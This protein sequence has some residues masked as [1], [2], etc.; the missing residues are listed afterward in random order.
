[1]DHGAAPDLCVPAP[2]DTFRNISLHDQVHKM[3]DAVLTSTV[4]EPITSVVC[5]NE[6]IATFALQA[7]CAHGLIVPRDMS[8]I[9]FGDTPGGGEALSPALTT[10]RP[11]IAQLATTAIAQLYALHRDADEHKAFAIGAHRHDI[12]YQGEMLKRSSTAVAKS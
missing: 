2:Y 3:V 6:S 5:Y 12:A 11:P 4:G 7:I 1:M 10:I 8:M 9:G